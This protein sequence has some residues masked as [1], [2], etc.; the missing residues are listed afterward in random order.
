MAVRSRLAAFFWDQ[1]DKMLCSHLFLP[2]SETLPA[3]SPQSPISSTLTFPASD[4]TQMLTKQSTLR[5]KC[6]DLK[7][8]YMASYEDEEGLKNTKV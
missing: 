6:S 2:C 3:S 5:E 4:P 8:A 7:E 1:D